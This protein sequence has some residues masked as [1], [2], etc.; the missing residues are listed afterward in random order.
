MNENPTT[1]ESIYRLRVCAWCGR[2]ALSG[3]W[4]AEE[5]AIRRLNLDP[6]GLPSLTHGICPDCVAAN[7][8]PPKAV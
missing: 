5:E 4:V 1:A 2:F 7:P 6:A 3:V 8:V